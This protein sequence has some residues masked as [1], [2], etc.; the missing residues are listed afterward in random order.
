MKSFQIRRL[1]VLSAVALAAA[2]T[3][4]E[5]HAR[6]VSATPIAESTVAPTRII[7]LRFSEELAPKFSGAELMQATGS[8]T[9][10]TSTVKDGKVIELTTQAPLQH[11]SYMVMW[12]AVA[13]D[14]GH[15]TKGSF[16]FT[17]R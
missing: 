16:N 15:K 2:A 10:A 8:M 11:G 3:Q 9:P 13:S 4:A 12:H 6:L 14:D 1:V 17:V 5:A 7:T